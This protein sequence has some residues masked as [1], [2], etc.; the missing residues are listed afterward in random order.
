M[1]YI[2]RLIGTPRSKYGH[3]YQDE[4]YVKSFVFLIRIVCLQWA[5]DIPFLFEYFQR[6]F[7]APL[8]LA[9]AKGQESRAWR[10]VLL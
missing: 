1:N 9:W 4:E 8:D 3:A 7:R 5:F 2:D 10:S 6:E